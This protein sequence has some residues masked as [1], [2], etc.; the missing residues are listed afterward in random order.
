MNEPETTTETREVIETTTETVTT[1]E[2]PYCED[3]RVPS[4]EF[5]TVELGPQREQ[6]AI[7]L[8]CAESAFG[9]TGDANGLT[10]ETPEAESVGSHDDTELTQLVNLA[11]GLTVT[12]VVATVGMNVATEAASQLSAAEVSQVGAPIMTP[13]D[14]VLVMMFLMIV[15]AFYRMLSISPPR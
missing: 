7:C 1:A 4:N 2:C 15:A 14:M 6:T 8:T 5:V 12:A 13:V 9:Y 10:R 11:I 3:N